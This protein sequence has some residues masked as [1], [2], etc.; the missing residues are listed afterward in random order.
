MSEPNRT[1]EHALRCSR[2]GFKF[3][4]YD[5]ERPD[6]HRWRVYVDGRLE[7]QVEPGQPAQLP[8]NAQA[9][10]WEVKLL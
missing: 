5:A 10:E 7:W 4:Q 2:R 3:R 9:L 6:R 8:A 1:I